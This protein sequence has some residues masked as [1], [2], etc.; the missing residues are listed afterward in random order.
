[1]TTTTRF[2]G[3]DGDDRDAAP[4]PVEQRSKSKTVPTRDRTST[5]EQGAGES[6]LAVRRVGEEA[7]GK[8]AD[9]VQGATAGEETHDS[10][11]KGAHTATAEAERE[12]A[13]IKRGTDRRAPCE[14]RDVQR[15]DSQQR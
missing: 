7:A 5:C 9:R 15:G 2:G 8:G 11:H 6:A 3:G 10:R 4:P 13:D 12:H 14:A 1:M